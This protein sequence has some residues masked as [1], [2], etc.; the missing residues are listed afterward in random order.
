MGSRPYLTG[1]CLIYFMR[2]APCIFSASE[3]AAKIEHQIVQ[4]NKPLWP[5]G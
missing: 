4:V 5:S 2:S 3:V 1:F